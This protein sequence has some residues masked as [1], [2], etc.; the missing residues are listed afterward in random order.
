[1]VL[2]VIRKIN[3]SNRVKVSVNLEVIIRDKSS[4]HGFDLGSTSWIFSRESDFLKF[5]D[6]LMPPRKSRI[7][8]APLDRKKKKE[9][10]FFYFFYPNLVS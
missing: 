6:S 5:I 9:K 10:H 8:M 4:H 1:M 3:T 7:S 2:E